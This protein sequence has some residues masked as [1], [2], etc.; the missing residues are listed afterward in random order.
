MMAGLWHILRIR[1]WHLALLG[2]AGLCAVG[3]GSGEI[4]RYNI[5]GTVNYNGK[6]VPAGTIS[7]EPVGRE[8]SP[9]FATIRDGKY[10]TAE[11]GVGQV[12]GEHV[13]KITGDARP[14]V[15][16]N[17]FQADSYVAKELF[18]KFQKNAVLP[19]RRS[20]QDFEVPRST[21]K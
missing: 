5:S 2:L 18:P 17:S 21:K 13:V 12:G 14:P 1:A 9:G 20:T 10:D 6:P 7:F 11:N 19:K 15:D 8:I 16:P 3:C 4:K